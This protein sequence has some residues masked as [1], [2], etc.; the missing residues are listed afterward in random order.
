MAKKKPNGLTLNDISFITSE[1]ILKNVP[2]VLFLGFLATIYIANAHYAERNVRR[3]QVIQKELKEMRW[4]YMSLQSD[5]MYNS[6]R[7]EIVESVKPEGLKPL[8][9]KPK[10]IVVD[11]DGY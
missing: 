9:S 5:N 2:F 7:S 3:I 4:Q 11:K 6:K 10:K 8:R 1:W